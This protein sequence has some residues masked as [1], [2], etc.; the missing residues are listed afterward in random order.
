MIT[1]GTLQFFFLVLY[2][3]LS[4]LLLLSDVSDSSNISTSIATAN[5]YLAGIPFHYFLLSVVATLAFL[6]VFEAAFWAYKGVRW[7]YN[8]IPGIS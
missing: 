5:G 6:I 7:L 4:P 3:I 1:A 2:A 8:K